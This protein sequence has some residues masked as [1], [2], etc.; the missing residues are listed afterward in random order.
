MIDL[1]LLFILALSLTLFLS[2]VLVALSFFVRCMSMSR[3]ISCIPRIRFDFFVGLLHCIS[4]Q[5]S[6][7]FF[8]FIV[9]FLILCVG[10]D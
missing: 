4:A 9:L 2:F 6:F 10:S 5:H 8:V 7:L 1:F 3:R